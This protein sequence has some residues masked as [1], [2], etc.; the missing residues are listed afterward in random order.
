MV[1]P[2]NLL[3]S[4]RAKS[5]NLHLRFFS[6][7]RNDAEYAEWSGNCAE[8]NFGTATFK[9]QNC[10]RCV[11]PVPPIPRHKVGAM[12]RIRAMHSSLTDVMNADS[13]NEADNADE[14]RIRSDTA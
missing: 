9:K 7:S 12:N 8:W 6:P 5:R 4:F 3:G 11:R 13:A 1:I 14:K 2:S 10:P